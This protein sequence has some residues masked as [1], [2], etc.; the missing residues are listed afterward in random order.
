MNHSTE[1]TPTPQS[2][3]PIIVVA[4]HVR[5]TVEVVGPNKVRFAR[6]WQFYQ[7]NVSVDYFTPTEARQIAAAL[8]ALADYQEGKQ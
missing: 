5:F 8:I 7:G 3:E 6:C 1:P 2:P 4:D